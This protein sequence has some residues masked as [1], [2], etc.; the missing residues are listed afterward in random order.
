MLSYHTFL[1]FSREELFLEVKFRR[2]E[3]DGFIR[4]E[5]G[6]FTAVS[7]PCTD[8]L[9]RPGPARGFL[10]FHSLHLLIIISI[11]VGIAINI[12]LQSVR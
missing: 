6:N 5:Y 11:E 12:I 7:Y 8:L 2:T 10:K 3:F 9:F 1:P 4:R